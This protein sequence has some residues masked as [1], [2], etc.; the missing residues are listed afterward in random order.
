MTAAVIV[1][2]FGLQAS[3]HDHATS[4]VR[5][6]LPSDS[7][8]GAY[9]RS[10]WISRGRGVITQFAGVRWDSTGGWTLVANWPDSDDAGAKAYF[11]EPPMRGLLA[12]AEATHDVEL[13]GEAAGFF[14]AYT[15]RF[16][17][18]ADILAASRRVGGKS[19]LLPEG[20]P[21]DRTL[22]W[23]DRR[24]KPPWPSENL[25]CNAQFLHPAARLLRLA[26]GYPAAS[27]PPAI[28]RFAEVYLPMLVGE[29]LI[30]LGYVRNYGVPG[31]RGA[32]TQLVPLWEAVLNSPEG[33]LYQVTDRDL[34]LIATA[35][36]LLEAHR[37]DPSFIPLLGEETRLRRLVIVGARLLMTRTV[38]HRDTRDRDGRQVGSLGYFEGDMDSDPEMAFAGYSGRDFPGAEARRA[39]EGA[40]WDVSHM[41]RLPVVFRSLW[42]ARRGIGALDSTTLALTINQ[43]LYVAFQGDYRLPTFNNFFDGTDGW[44]RVNYSGRQGWGYPPSR[45]CD[46]R[47]HNRPCLSSGAVAGWGLLAFGNPDLVRLGNG[48]VALARSSEPDAKD[49]RARVYAS[50]QDDFTWSDTTSPSS[51]LLA[52]VMAEYLSGNANASAP[53]QAVRH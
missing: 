41:Q 24:G 51:M 2:L 8:R 7:A 11:V 37:S 30:R 52:E 32:P 53:V 22:P 19:P 16:R 36:E 40:S 23:L 29:H 27:R 26:A 39:P 21:T 20:A 3:L 13:L 50:S 35:A 45:Y 17:T 5:D 43:Y 18:V 25:L 28:S 14:L 42:D 38:Q 4:V 47:D 31:P 49:L 33:R 34:W 10:V 15:P 46:A 12:L 6:S 48:L 44:Y 9:V 1:A